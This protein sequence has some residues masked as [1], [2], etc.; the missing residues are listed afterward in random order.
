MNEVIIRATFI[1]ASRTGVGTAPCC[2]PQATGV[3]PH[4]RMETAAVSG[5]S[6]DMPR[7][8]TV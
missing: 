8:S 6:P 1:Y 4:H 5:Q 3:C 2:W 7:L